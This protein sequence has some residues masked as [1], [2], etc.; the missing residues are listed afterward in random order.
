MIV[1]LRR[2]LSKCNFLFASYSVP[3][4]AR[5]PRLLNS[6]SCAGRLSLELLL[7]IN[8][9]CK[10]KGTERCVHIQMFFS[11]PMAK[12][13][14]FSVFLLLV[15]LSKLRSLFHF[16][17]WIFLWPTLFWFS[18]SNEPTHA[19]RDDGCAFTITRSVFPSIVSHKQ[20]PFIL[21]SECSLGV[22]LPPC[23]GTEE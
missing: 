6:N 13:A 22:K 4:R 16:V 5:L 1:E 7:Q 18:S 19:A 9:M 21:R 10:Y 23:H 3:A 11:I 2:Q 20:I 12:L 8:T 15:L 14:W 17:I